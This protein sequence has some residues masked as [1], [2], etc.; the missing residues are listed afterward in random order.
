MSSGFRLSF[1]SFLQPHHGLFL[2]RHCADVSERS[3]RI[4]GALPPA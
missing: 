2:D 3:A 4:V 1:V